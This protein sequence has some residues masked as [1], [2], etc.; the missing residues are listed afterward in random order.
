MVVDDSVMRG[1]TMPYVVRLLK[2]FGAKEVHVRIAAPPTRYGCHLGVDLPF[3]EDLLAHG[4]SVEQV[5]EWMSKEAG[6]SVDSLEYLSLPDLIKATGLP[7]DS[8]C[9]GC[10]D[11]NWPVARENE[12]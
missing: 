7:A 12:A 10:W 4:K 8:F 3:D 11:K 9:T 1:T 5:R 6:V 2:R